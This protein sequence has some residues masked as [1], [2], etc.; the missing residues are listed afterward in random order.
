MKSAAKIN[1]NAKKGSP[2]ATLAGVA[3]DRPEVSIAA[4]LAA[5]LRRMFAEIPDAPRRPSALATHLGVSRVL[6]SRTLG[7]IALPN[8]LDM[9]QR[10]PGP[11]TL[12]GIVEEL[13][14]DVM[15]EL[16]SD[17]GTKAFTITRELVEERTQ[18]L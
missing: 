4:E 8:P 18:A 1:P 15:Y 3:S 2:E 6:I 5:S 14:L 9:L 16:P 11:E 10:V 17:K 12:R 7:A 13:M